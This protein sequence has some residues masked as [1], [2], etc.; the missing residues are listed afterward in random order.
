MR[1]LQEQ[2]VASDR[3]Y[4]LELVSYQVADGIL[5]RRTH[6]ASGLSVRFP[7]RAEW[8]LTGSSSSRRLAMGVSSF[9]CTLEGGSFGGAHS[10]TF[11]LSFTPGFRGQKSV[12]RGFSLEFAIFWDNTVNQWRKEED[13]GGATWAE[14]RV[15]QRLPDGTFRRWTFGAGG[16]APSLKT[17]ADANELKQYWT[18]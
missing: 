1:P 11:A 9:Q 2:P 5:T 3:A 10:R 8:T 13:L 12:K 7:A 18:R 14:A 6:D 17:Y 15:F 16:G 4:G